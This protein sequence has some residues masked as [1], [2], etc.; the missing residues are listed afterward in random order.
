[1]KNIHLQFI[2]VLTKYWTARLNIYWKWSSE[3]AS[4]ASGLKCVRPWWANINTNRTLNLNRRANILK[5]NNF[6][7]SWSE[8]I[9]IW[10]RVATWK[11]LPQ[12]IVTKF[13]SLR[14]DYMHAVIFSSSTN[15]YQYI[16]SLGI[17]GSCVEHILAI[18]LSHLKIM[19]I[20]L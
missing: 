17:N 12:N 5:P 16:P 1:M 8:G 14:F 20:H 2:F 4:S 18:F 15:H 7:K 19:K 6:L 10:R 9:S 11:C 13:N 3:G